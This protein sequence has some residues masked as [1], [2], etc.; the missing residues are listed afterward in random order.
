VNEALDARLIDHGFSP[1]R[2]GVYLR[3]MTPDVSGWAGIGLASRKRGAE[4]DADAMVGVRHAG[5]ERRVPFGGK[6]YDATIFRPLYELLPDREYQTWTFHDRNIEEQAESLAR[7]IDE[8]GGVLMRQLT[9]LDCI[10]HALRDWAFADVRRTRVPLV[11]L[12]KGNLHAARAAFDRFAR[13]LRDSTDE[14][15]LREY[16]HFGSALFDRAM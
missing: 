9:T 16:E 12:E 15:E 2:R 7:A 13:E 6:V 8:H 4:V 11:L 5:V 10:E 1:M 14:A 3:R